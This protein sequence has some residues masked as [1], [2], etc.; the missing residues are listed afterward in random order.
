MILVKLFKEILYP[1]IPDLCY[2]VFQ[3]SQR[4][5]S[6]AL[7]PVLPKTLSSLKGDLFIQKIKR[8]YPHKVPLNYR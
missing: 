5:F 6:K 4:K 8:E 1:S 3:V 2:N 7:K